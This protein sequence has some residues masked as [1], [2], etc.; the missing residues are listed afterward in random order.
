M[1]SYVWL[2]CMYCLAV[3]C[4][5]V[6]GVLLTSVLFYPFSQFCEINIP[7][8]ACKN[9][10]NSPKSISEGVEYG[11]YVF[12][13]G[14][15]VCFPL[16]FADFHRGSCQGSARAARAARIIIITTVCVVMCLVCYLLL[17]WAGP[18]R[19]WACPEGGPQGSCWCQ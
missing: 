14:L 3:M 11:K 9:S 7:S 16:L 1:C 15:Q 17:W 10:K 18:A 2:F 19:R 5:Y 6:F 12:G 13:Q 4:C 8:W